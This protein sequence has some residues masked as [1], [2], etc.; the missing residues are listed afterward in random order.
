MGGHRPAGPESATT[1]PTDLAIQCENENLDGELMTLP[2]SLVLTKWST[3]LIVQSG[4]GVNVQDLSL[5]AW[6]RNG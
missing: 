4:A 1:I 2:A 3:T 6:P 5:L